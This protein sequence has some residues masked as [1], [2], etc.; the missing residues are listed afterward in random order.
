[1]LVVERRAAADAA[2]RHSLLDTDTDDDVTYGC[3]NEIGTMLQKCANKTKLQSSPM[4]VITYITIHWFG[5]Y[6]K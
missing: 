2:S 3:G 5:I 6:G 1:L 4:E